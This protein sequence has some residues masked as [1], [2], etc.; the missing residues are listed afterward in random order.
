MNGVVE[1]ATK[2]VPKLQELVPYLPKIQNTTSPVDPNIKNPT[3]E[4]FRNAFKAKFENADSTNTD[5]VKLAEK[6]KKANKKS[7]KAF[8]TIEEIE[9][10]TDKEIQNYLVYEQ[11]TATV[12]L[13][14]TDEE[15]NKVIKQGIRHKMDVAARKLASDDPETKRQLEIM[16]K[17]LT[18][19]LD[20]TKNEIIIPNNT[21]GQHGKLKVKKTMGE[22]TLNAFQQFIIQNGEKKKRNDEQVDLDVA[23]GMNFE[24]EIDPEQQAYLDGPDGKSHFLAKQFFSIRTKQGRKR[25]SPHYKVKIKSSSPNYLAPTGT[26][27]IQQQIG[28]LQTHTEGIL[29]ENI[30]QA[31][32]DKKQQLGEDSLVY[33]ID[34]QGKVIDAYTQ[35]ELKNKDVDILENK[36]NLSGEDLQNFIAQVLFTQNET[37]FLDTVN[38]ERENALQQAVDETP[39]A[40]SRETTDDTKREFYKFF[41][42]LKGERFNNKTGEYDPALKEHEMGL[43]VGTRLRVKTGRDSE[44]KPE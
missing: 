42:N 15:R 37:E 13:P 1:L 38:E 19:L 12:T 30:S 5:F 25:I 44:L 24:I 17:N 9:Q 27:P 31:V 11:G 18:N 28:H 3:P 6:F 8:A 22:G 23:L 33:L 43:K 10:A 21:G 41:Q 36:I 16:E 4:E 35:D 14:Q 40:E 34:D 29:D 39:S 26:D 32:K 20:L 7:G 2:P